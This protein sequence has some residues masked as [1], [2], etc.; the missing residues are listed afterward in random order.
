MGFAF[1][2]GAVTL[3]LVPGN[4]AVFTTD[5]A[6]QHHPMRSEIT[7]RYHR[8][9]NPKGDPALKSRNTLD[10][11]FIRILILLQREIFRFGIFTNI[12][13]MK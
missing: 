10:C 6:E 13:T 4:S 11:A 7:V 5:R 9:S 1:Y 2:S 3:Y 8:Q 12:K